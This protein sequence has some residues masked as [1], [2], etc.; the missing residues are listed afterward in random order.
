[1]SNPITDGVTTCNNEGLGKNQLIYGSFYNF[2]SGFEFS[3]YNHDDGK[4]IICLSDQ[5]KKGLCLGFNL[6]PTLVVSVQ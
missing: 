1:M 4:K 5:E 6:V 3:I 2:S